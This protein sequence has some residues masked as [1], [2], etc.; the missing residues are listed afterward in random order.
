M[1]DRLVLQVEALTV[2]YCTVPAGALR[3][4][5]VVQSGASWF[6]P[7][8]CPALVLL[9]HHPSHGP[10]L[11]DTGYSPRFFE[12]TRSWPERSYAL[13]TP[14]TLPRAQ[15]LVAQLATRGIAPQD[16]RHV[17]ITHCHA[18]H[19]AGLRD[20]PNAQFYLTRQALNPFE[21]LRGAIA[22]RWRATRAGFLPELLPDD[23][24]ER[25]VWI[26]DRGTEDVPET[27]ASLVGTERGGRVRRAYDV[28]GDES[29]LAIDVPGHAPGMI[30]IAMR[31]QAGPLLAVADAVW[32][33]DTLRP[34]AVPS[35]VEQR[36]GWNRVDAAETLR[37]LQHVQRDSHEG[38]LLPSH[39]AAAIAEF[40]AKLG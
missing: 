24:R 36:I 26:D 33:G 1:T 4:K 7:T 6:A 10:V 31:T 3:P 23:F 5:G 32:L 11:M 21:K 14:V 2:G 15:Q 17:I 18:D 9:I 28:F 19:V 30:A 40:S 29:I 39:D 16:V 34:G 37:R 20:Y 25:A 35:L 8:R 27:L 13:T 12:A 38:F 22:G